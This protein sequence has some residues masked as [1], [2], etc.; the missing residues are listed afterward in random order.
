MHMYIHCAPLYATRLTN[1]TI[2]SL[3]V[4]GALTLF[5]VNA[6][7]AILTATSAVSCAENFVFQRWNN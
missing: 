4:V 3:P 2:L 5:R 6:H 1:V 7:S